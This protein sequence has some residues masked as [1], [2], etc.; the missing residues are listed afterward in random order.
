M[1]KTEA[2]AFLGVSERAIERYKKAGKLPARI[3]RK[4]GGDGKPR[5]TLEFDQAD[6]ERF[7]AELNLETFHALAV[8]YQTDTNRQDERAD[9]VRQPDAATIAAQ[10][11]DTDL[12][13]INSVL[14]ELARRPSDAPTTADNA[15]PDDTRGQSDQLAPPI[16]PSPVA[17]ALDAIAG[18]FQMQTL[19]E[20]LSFSVAEAALVSGFAESYLR[21]AIAEQ[22]LTAKRRGRSLNIKRA[23]LIAFVDHD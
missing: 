6:L 12:M 22:R 21:R 14:A 20:K 16:S 23:D 19:K 18:N 3:L 11:T 8:D 10:R 7:Q 15:P 9:N 5:P 1:N 2:A 17:A 13:P 4:K